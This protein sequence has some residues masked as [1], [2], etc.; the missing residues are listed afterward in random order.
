MADTALFA[1]QH[2]NVEIGQLLRGDRWAGSEFWQK[3][4]DPTLT[5]E[6]LI[7]RSEIVVLGLDGGGLDDLY[8][9]AALGRSRDDPQGLAWLVACLVSRECPCSE[10]KQSRQRCKD[11]AAAGELTICR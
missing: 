7:E 6:T 4:T 9:L 3:Q 1:S 5:L 10:G 8:G 2:F 11:F